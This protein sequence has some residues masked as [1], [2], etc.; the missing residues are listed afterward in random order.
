MKK[1]A[2]FNLKCNFFKKFSL[3][4]IK[5][6]YLQNNQIGEWTEVAKHFEEF[7]L[8]KKG[9]VKDVNSRLF[10][11]IIEVLATLDDELV[12]FKKDDKCNVGLKCLNEIMLDL[13]EFRYGIVNKVIIKQYILI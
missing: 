2:I 13:K 12:N 3:G 9:E 5:K 8:I 10:H 6:L 1:K 11:D 4:L 7:E